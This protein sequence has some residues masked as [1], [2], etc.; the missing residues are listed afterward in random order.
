MKR[1]PSENYEKETHLTLSEF[2]DKVSSFS[3]F[4]RMCDIFSAFVEKGNS[5]AL[6]QNNFEFQI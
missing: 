6:L 5:S 2:S 4:C 1:K 3:C